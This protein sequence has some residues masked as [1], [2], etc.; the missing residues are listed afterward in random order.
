M[1]KAVMLILAMVAIAAVVS[2]GPVAAKTPDTVPVDGPIS[3]INAILMDI[4]ATVHEIRDILSG[5]GELRSTVGAIDMNVSHLQTGVGSIEAEVGV[6]TMNVSDIQREVGSMRSEI[7]TMQADISSIQNDIQM[8]IGGTVVYTTAEF[9]LSSSE[10]LVVEVCG[11]T[12]EEDVDIPIYLY[13]KD[14][15]AYIVHY[16]FGTPHL[17][18]TNQAYT[19]V[20]H[21]SG[22]Y[23]VR[24][25]VPA[26]VRDEI[27][28]KAVRYDSGI[29]IEEYLPGDFKIDYS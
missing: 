11:P 6:I 8:F 3:D 24:I 17:N 26:A 14:D 21:G 23:I 27:I 10:A 22:S 29:I 9:P 2:C 25:E 20:F 15:N 4:N 28:P 1:K 5:F 18:R 12:L 19:G 13:D 7:S 16:P